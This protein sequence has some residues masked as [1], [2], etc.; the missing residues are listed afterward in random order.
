[1]GL[2]WL[3]VLLAALLGG[4]G[5]AAWGLW[6]LWRRAS[7]VG[8]ALEHLMGRLEE[9]GEILGRIDPGPLEQ[10]TGKR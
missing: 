3:W 6:W 5:L 7:A 4:L 10:G 9:A 8:A 1:M 2:L